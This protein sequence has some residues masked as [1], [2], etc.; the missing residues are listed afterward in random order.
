MTY[1][2]T[3]RG[4]SLIELLLAIFILGIGI[5]SIATLFPAGIA[6]QLKT[7]DDVIGPIVARNALTLIRSRVEQEDFGGAE[8][9][10][11]EWSPFLCGFSLTQNS[12]NPWPT[13]CGDWMWRRPALV[14]DDYGDDG[15][16]YAQSVRGAIDIFATPD[17]NILG[18]DGAPLTEYWTDTRGLPGIPYNKERYPDFYDP[19]NGDWLGLNVPTKRI[20]ASERQYPMWSGAP[21]DR[22]KAEYYWD[23]MFKRFEGRMQVAVFVYRVIDPTSDGPYTIDTKGVTVPNLPM[24]VNLTSDTSTGSWNAVLGSEELIGSELDDP[25]V[26]NGQW[27]YPGQWLVDQNGNIHTVRRGRRRMS[28]GN[29]VLLNTS[30]TEVSVFQSTEYIGTPG[31][32]VNWWDQAATNNIQ[33]GFVDMGVVTDIWY[34]PTSDTQGR[35]LI[36]VYVTVEDL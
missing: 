23:C 4:F 35:K 16:Y 25:S 8:P 19:D 36:P 30:P 18:G 11:P 33:D 28:N 24:R 2:N 9:F 31:I 14:Q 15:D 3:R 34:V 29:P 26:A 12:I 22:P 6:Q 32:N 20:L 17:T 13:I 27:Q 1:S 5:I 21:L 10:E 7:T